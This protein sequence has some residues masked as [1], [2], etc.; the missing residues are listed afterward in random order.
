ME[1]FSFPR[2][3]ILNSYS[4]AGLTGG[5]AVYNGVHQCVD[6]HRKRNDGCHSPKDIRLTLSRDC[7]PFDRILL[8][9]D[10]IM[11]SRLIG[12][13]VIFSVKNFVTEERLSRPRP[14]FHVE[15]ARYNARSNWLSRPKKTNISLLH[16]PPHPGICYFRPALTNLSTVLA[17]RFSKRRDANTARLSNSYTGLDEATNKHLNARRNFQRSRVNREE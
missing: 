1:F 15:C 9:P 16:P 7:Y 3:E 8:A 14:I 6:I 4:K 17:R 10:E 13:S 12:L 11:A 2:F 5:H